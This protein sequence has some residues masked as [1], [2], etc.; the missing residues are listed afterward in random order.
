[1]ARKL[2][3]SS[4]RAVFKKIFWFNLVGDAAASLYKSNY[5][6]SLQQGFYFLHFFFVMCKKSQGR[7]S[8]FLGYM[9]HAFCL[10]KACSMLTIQ[11]NVSFVSNSPS[12]SCF[13]SARSFSDKELLEM[14]ATLSFQM[15][16][17]RDLQRHR[18]SFTCPFAHPPNIL[19]HISFSLCFQRLFPSAQ[20]VLFL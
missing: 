18:D 5:F 12:V 7:I 17:Y 13:F 6:T 4:M 1:M 10:L 14:W 11:K 9:G 15:C 19:Y 8:T 2:H 3:F 20:N 16:V